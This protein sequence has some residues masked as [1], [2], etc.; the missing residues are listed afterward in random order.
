MFGGQAAGDLVA[1]CRWSQCLRI[2]LSFNA[3]A[4]RRSSPRGG[5]GGSA[6]SPSTTMPACW[7]GRQRRSAG[8]RGRSP[9]RTSFGLAASWR[10]RAGPRR[11]GAS[12]CRFSRDSIDSFKPQGGRDRNGVW[13]QAGVPGR[14]VQ[15]VSSCGRRL[16][17]AAAAATP[18]RVGEFFDFMKLRIATAPKY[19][20]AARDYA[21]FRTLY[22]GGLRSD[23][24]ALLEIPDVHFN[25]GPFGKL[26]VRFGEGAH[27]SGP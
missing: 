20:P 26:Q 6:R 9:P 8:W 7:S 25:R 16:A 1:P 3:N 15:R 17:G 14:R 4:S 13:R 12:M 24:A 18:E 11:P 21:L 19:S 22:H 23:E 2:R 10:W 5:R 27:T